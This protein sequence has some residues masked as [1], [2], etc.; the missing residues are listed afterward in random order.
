MH[1]LGGEGFCQSR[2]RGNKLTEDPT[3][4]EQ[5]GELPGLLDIK[6]IY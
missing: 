1:H 4:V 6:V 2:T 3:H 5:G